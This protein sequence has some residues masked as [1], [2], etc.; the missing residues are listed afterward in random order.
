MYTI[1]T[2]VYDGN[3]RRL[4]M[5]VAGEVITYTVDYAGDG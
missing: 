1:T 4:Q 3:G 2:F 5:S